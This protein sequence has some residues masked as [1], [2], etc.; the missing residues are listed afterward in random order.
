MLRF[1]SP[2]W[3][4]ALDDAVR[5]VAVPSD[6]A[7]SLRVRYRF[8]G[9]VD[10]RAG[11]D[12]AGHEVAGYDLAGREVAGYDIVL[13]DGPARAEPPATGPTADAG[14]PGAGA[15]GRSGGTV[16]I[17]QPLAVA[18]RV[19]TGA[20]AAQQALLAGDIRVEGPV[21]ELVRWR[22]LLDALD[23]ASASLRDRTTW[24]R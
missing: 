13:G 23:A 10:D 15:G 5:Q 20:L 7:G 19:A 17:T 9:G 14:G 1:A 2:E 8:T 11:H 21:V 4:A 16:T 24:E 12:R 3:I 18:H 6:A 22:P